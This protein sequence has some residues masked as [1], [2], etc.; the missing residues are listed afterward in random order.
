MR[1]RRGRVTTDYEASNGRELSDDDLSAVLAAADGELMDY[2]EAAAEPADALLAIMDGHKTGS[3][4]CKQ[5]SEAAGVIKMRSTARR[6]ADYLE[7]DIEL[8]TALV[9]GIERADGRTRML[10][11]A[12]CGSSLND[13]VDVHRLTGSLNRELADGAFYLTGILSEANCM[14]IDL[15]NR[16]AVYADEIHAGA[17]ECYEVLS[18]AG[19]EIA[20]L[21]PPLAQACEIFAA[22]GRRTARL[23]DLGPRADVIREEARSLIGLYGSLRTGVHAA[24]DD[25]HLAT[26]L[27]PAREL[28]GIQADVSGVDL[29]DA[30]IDM[31]ALA[32]VIWTSDTTWPADIADDVRAGSEE[33]RPGVY[34]VRGPGTGRHNL[35]KV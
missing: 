5:A 17:V 26:V 23:S 22:I 29:S 4:V 15:M 18:R 21:R 12:L 14:A 11:N 13:V 33:L 19:N 24:L 27:N 28:A 3:T 1:R 34:K 35:V 32:D 16:A 7:T 9:L 2:I 6:L 31:E 10:L 20:N 30:H 25:L 8:A